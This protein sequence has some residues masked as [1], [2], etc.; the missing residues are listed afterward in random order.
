[1]QQCQLMNVCGM[2]EKKLTKKHTKPRKNTVTNESVLNGE[3]T[4]VVVESNIGKQRMS[5]CVDIG[6]VCMQSCVISLL[7]CQCL[8]VGRIGGEEH[9][10][11]NRL[12]PRW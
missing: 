3:A 2:A 6:C 8:L 9:E 4:S 1:M 10:R 5:K 7:T 11:I 12:Q